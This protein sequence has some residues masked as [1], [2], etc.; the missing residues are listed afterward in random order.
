[1]RADVPCPSDVQPPLIIPHIKMWPRAASGKLPSQP[2][3]VGRSRRTGSRRALYWGGYFGADTPSVGALT[4]F[5]A[6]GQSRKTGACLLQVRFTPYPDDPERRSGCRRRARSQRTRSLK[7]RSERRRGHHPPDLQSPWVNSAL[8]AQAYYCAV[9][10]MLNQCLSAMILKAPIGLAKPFKGNSPIG[11]A[12]TKVSKSVKVLRLV[13]ICPP[14]AS[15]HRRAAI[16]VTV[17]T[18]P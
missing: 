13:R 3:G 18:A 9:P 16:F 2:M 12:S 15:P 14:L 5:S 11:S 6:L 10:R 4:L 1:M 7:S 8:H 17:P